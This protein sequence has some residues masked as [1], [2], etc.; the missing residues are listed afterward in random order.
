MAAILLT[1]LIALVGLAA[2][3]SLADSGLRWWSAFGCL[4]QE[5]RGELV[6]Q[7]RVAQL[8]YTIT[9]GGCQGFERSALAR[10]VRQSVRRA[11]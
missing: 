1:A 4:R 10:G 5:M 2:M 11:A 6:T 7:Q 9:V 3:G 8:R